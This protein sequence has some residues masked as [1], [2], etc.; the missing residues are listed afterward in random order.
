MRLCTYGWFPED[1]GIM[2]K[3]L[4][5][6]QRW[7]PSR[8]LSPSTN[9]LRVMVGKEQTVAEPSSDLFSNSDKSLSGCG[10]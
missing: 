5:L 3:G 1:K 8:N 2:S 6:F 7:K 4:R 9:K 10:K